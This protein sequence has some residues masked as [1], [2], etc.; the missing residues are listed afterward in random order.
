MRLPGEAVLPVFAAETAPEPAPRPAAA[1]PPKPKAEPELQL[2]KKVGCNMCMGRGHL[3]HLPSGLNQAGHSSA[4]GGDPCATC[5]C[6]S[7]VRCSSREHNVC[8]T[9]KCFSLH[10]TYTARGALWLLEPPGVHVRGPQ[11]ALRC[12]SHISSCI[13][14]KCLCVLA[15]EQQQR[16]K[17]Q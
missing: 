11:H 7:T 14:S 10:S 3:H 2:K 5:C 15:A 16:G 1:A 4:V 6:E 8:H 17:L 13:T 12:L 9:W